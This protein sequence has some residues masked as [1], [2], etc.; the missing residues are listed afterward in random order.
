MKPFTGS[1]I[2]AL[3]KLRKFAGVYTHRGAK[4]RRGE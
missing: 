2:S 3:R 4:E 1:P